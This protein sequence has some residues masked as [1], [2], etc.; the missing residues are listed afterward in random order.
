MN[1]A[2]FDNTGVINLLRLKFSSPNNY[3]LW[4]GAEFLK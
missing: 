4:V 2:V 3:R 1:T